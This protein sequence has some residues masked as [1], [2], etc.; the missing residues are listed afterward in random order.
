MKSWSTSTGLP[1][2]RSDFLI[3]GDRFLVDGGVGVR[4]LLCLQI[5]ADCDRLLRMPANAC[6]DHQLVKA[7]ERCTSCEAST[8]TATTLT[9]SRHLDIAVALLPDLHGR[10]HTEDER[11]G[12]EAKKLFQ[13]A[14]DML[15]RAPAYSLPPLCVAPALPPPMHAVTCG[16]RG[17][18]RRGF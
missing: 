14:K 2:S 11:V 10:I 13:E 9:S 6:E 1:S 18:S 17:L 3:W 12:P 7:P 15:A 16:R 8:P 4:A 5:A